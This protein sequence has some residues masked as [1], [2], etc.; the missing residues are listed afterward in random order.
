[1][2]I[3]TLLLAAIFAAALAGCDGPVAGGD[4]GEVSVDLDLPDTECA[5]PATLDA[6]KQALFTRARAIGRTEAGALDGLAKGVTV[7]IEGAEMVADGIC[8]GELMLAAPAAAAGG[9]GGSSRL[10]ER[11]EYRPAGSSGQAIV[12]GGEAMIDRL[13]SFDPDRRPRPRPTPEDGAGNEAATAEENVLIALPPAD[14]ELNDADVDLP[15][16]P[17]EQVPEQAVQ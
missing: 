6:V 10:E 16:E 11:I 1:M 12:A 14:A 7:R 5:L 9:L 3:P 2:R 13:A 15:I 17:P 4:A 8:A